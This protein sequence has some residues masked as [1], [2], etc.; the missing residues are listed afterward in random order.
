[1]L[2]VVYV[3][4]VVSLLPVR[5]ET[6][7]IHFCL[8]IAASSSII[9]STSIKM[10]VKGIDSHLSHNTRVSSHLTREPVDKL[11]GRS[12][13]SRINVSTAVKLRSQVRAPTLT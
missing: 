3:K 8:L 5:A 2:V 13:R 11:F 4:A 6:S 7:S 1:M 10:L 12:R 9:P